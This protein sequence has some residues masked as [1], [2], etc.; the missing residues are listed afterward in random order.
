M[1]SEYQQSEKS[2]KK[3][4]KIFYTSSKISKSQN[5][6]EV[7]VQVEDF[8]L[9]AIQRGQNPTDFKP[10][11]IIGKGVAEIRVRTESAYRIF[12]VARFPEAIYVLRDRT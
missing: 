3:D 6:S 2:G 11:S 9:R 8:Q 4:K 1:D 10:M 5:D 12:Y 7:L